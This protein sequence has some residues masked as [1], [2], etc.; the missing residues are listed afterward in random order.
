MAQTRDAGSILGQHNCIGW[1]SHLKIHLLTICYTHLVGPKH[2][3]GSQYDLI[4]SSVY[5]TITV[6]R[7]DKPLTK[8]KLYIQEVFRSDIS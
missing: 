1:A 3:L 5:T 2:P 7:C 6:W 8:A 4:I